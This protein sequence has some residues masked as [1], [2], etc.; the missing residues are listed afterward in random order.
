VCGHAALLMEVSHAIATPG[1]L[2]N[3]VDVV[4]RRFRLV[5]VRFTK[6][7]MYMAPPV[8]RTRVRPP[9]RLR[10][11]TDLGVSSAAKRTRLAF[12]PASPGEDPA[13]PRKAV[14]GRQP[15]GRDKGVDPAVPAPAYVICTGHLGMAVAESRLPSRRPR[16]WPTR[17]AATC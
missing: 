14:N 6:Y 10:A 17:S 1:L 12:P 7:A 9:H 4:D 3:R 13:V 2:S 15:A 5:R 8:P 16:N 11:G